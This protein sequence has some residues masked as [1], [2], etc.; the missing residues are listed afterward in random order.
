MVR[1]NYLKS[2]KRRWF[3]F[4]TVV[5]L[6]MSCLFL[7]RANKH[8]S[9]ENARVTRHRLY[10]TSHDR[11]SVPKNNF[12]MPNLSNSAIPWCGKWAVVAPLN[13][14]WASEAVRRQ[15]RMHNWCLVIVLE[16][17]LSETY[18]T[19]WFEGEGNKAVVVLSPK[20]AK[21]IG[22]NE[23]VKASPWNYNGRKNIGYYYAITHG[24]NTIWDFDDE[25]ML[26]FWI[27]GAAPPGAPSIDGS[28]PEGDEDV[29]VDVLEPNAHK[30]PTWNPYPAMGAPAL[31]SW[32]RGLPLDDATNENCN[33][34]ELK[35][36]TITKS[37]IAVLQSLSDHQ[38]D[39]DALY[40]AIMPFPF[41]FKKREMKPVMVPPFSMTP[42]NER[43]TLH[44]KVGF[45][46][47]F[48]PTTMDR[49]LS[50][51]WRSYIA[52]RLFWEVG[53]RVGFIGRPLVVQDHT[54]HNSLKDI[55]QIKG[56]SEKIR[57][58]IA[59]LVSQRKEVVTLPDLL[60]ELWM[61]LYKSDFI[62]FNDLNLVKM[63]L[64]SLTKAEYKFPELLHI[65]DTKRF[66]NYPLIKSSLESAFNRLCPKV[67]ET[68]RYTVMRNA[69]EYDATQC[70][71]DDNKSLTFWTSDIHFASRLD[72]TSM[73]GSLGNKVLIAIGYNYN[74]NPSVWKMPGMHLYNRIS[75]V[76]KK[77]Y[78]RV[79]AMNN[80]LTEKMVIDNFEFYKNDTEMAEVD[81]FLCT[82]QPGMCEMWMP[83][84]KTIVF[85]P[86]HRYNMGR[87]TIEETE[88]LNKH[89][90][91]LASMDHPKHVISASSKYDLEYLRHYTGL[92]VLPLYAFT[93]YAG[94]YTY[95]P[96]RNEIALFVRK[97]YPYNN[98]DKRFE[99]EIKK[100]KLSDII[101]V[102][103]HYSFS[104]LI[105]YRAVVFVPYAVMTFKMNE[106]YLMSIPMFFP[107]MKYFRTIRAF[108]PD[109]SILDMPWC[110]AALN[111]TLNDTEMVAHPGSI[112]PYSPNMLNDV[113]SEFYWLQLADFSQWPHI[114]YFDDFKDLEEKLLTADF[115]KIHRLMV[116]ENKRRRSELENNWCKVFK[117][118]EK[119][120]RVPKD[121]ESA[122]RELYNVSRLQ[123]Y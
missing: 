120:R 82:F 8:Q 42:Y 75:G 94:K 113:E 91:T 111:S 116:E 31:P 12:L 105:Q 70:Q 107:S 90:Y 15:V 48:L 22:D 21:D 49:E 96:T 80:R 38:P 11:F 18:D 19:R 54:I 121:Y 115:E 45:W 63:W 3:M 86:S 87:C 40:Q 77:K 73:L 17:E 81:G 41:Y 106:L 2:V 122:I 74:R 123:V 62:T 84:N 95:Y 76:I 46:A 44:F 39:A 33:N 93:P 24:A 52:Q 1:K 64:N 109:R 83:F 25:N 88:R 47:L 55:S 117:K 5:V 56:L 13:A 112:H 103:K 108:G 89:L 43:A 98:S 85:V 35:S 28:L 51:I 57:K 71:K 26:K 68:E 101:K 10:A 37:S 99:T 9:V 65:N 23:F 27:P 4:S 50:D 114:T 118:M 14:D 32:P 36:T 6:V 60:K 53:L 72:Q 67:I 92:Q 102:Y 7:Y 34:V 29:D 119:G 97:A 69:P 61:A 66:L 58:L 100:F 20:I 104:D 30:Y 59:F 79:E 78:P 16:K 110:Q